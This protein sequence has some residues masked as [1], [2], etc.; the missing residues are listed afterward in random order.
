M[1][2]V[3]I[4]AIAFSTSRPQV[5]ETCAATQSKSDRA[6]AFDCK[7]K[8]HKCLSVILR[9]AFL[10]SPIRGNIRLR[11]LLRAL[12][13]KIASENCALNYLTKSWSQS[14]QFFFIFHSSVSYPSVFKCSS[15]LFSYF[16]T[17]SPAFPS[18][19][20]LISDIV[21]WHLLISPSSSAS[22]SVC[23]PFSSWQQ[24]FHRDRML[25][26]HRRRLSHEWHGGECLMSRVTGWLRSCSLRAGT[27]RVK[28][29]SKSA[30]LA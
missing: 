5:W 15:F 25:E 27:S 6:R 24:I 29:R 8:T 22:S 18:S 13:E 20:Y 14:N 3:S 1:S 16:S 19:M 28:S 2:F 11:V 4:S 26:S 30:P 7:V 17:I 21:L 9:E 10:L 12:V 23:S